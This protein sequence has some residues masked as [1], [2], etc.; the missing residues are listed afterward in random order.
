MQ[1][2]KRAHLDASL[3]EAELSNS[4]LEREVN[5]LKTG[6]REV[7]QLL[8]GTTP[9]HSNRRGGA[10]VAPIVTETLSEV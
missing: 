3:R 10:E 4:S 9:P 8:S 2:S 7:V 1:A 6:L 5:I